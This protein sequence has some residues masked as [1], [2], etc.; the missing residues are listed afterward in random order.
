MSETAS[1]VL[2][3][4]AEFRAKP[5]FRFT[6][7]QFRLL[8]PSPESVTAPLVAALDGCASQLSSLVESKAPSSALRQAIS[9]SLRSVDKPTDT[10]DREYL[11]YYYHE[12]GQMVGV[13]IAPVLNTWLYGPFLGFLLRVF[14]RA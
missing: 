8:N 12:L 10:E 11:A 3:A 5:K 4:L 13:S 1:V 9:R 2:T 7:A 6:E 14:N